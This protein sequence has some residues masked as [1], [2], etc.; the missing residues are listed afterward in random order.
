MQLQS[1]EIDLPVSKLAAKEGGPASFRGVF[2]RAPAIMEV[3]PNVEVLADYTVHVNDSTNA[4]AASFRGLEVC[5]FFCPSTSF[6]KI[7]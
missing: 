3:G 6:L 7:P 1:F 2:I 5:C 4:K